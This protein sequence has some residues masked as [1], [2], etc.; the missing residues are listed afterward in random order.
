VPGRSPKNGC[1]IWT[2]RKNSETQKPKGWGKIVTTRKSAECRREAAAS[3]AASKT[4]QNKI[5]GKE[6]KNPIKIKLQ[7][8]SVDRGSKVA[9]IVPLLIVGAFLILMAPSACAALSGYQFSLI[10]S[11][12]SPAPGGGTFV[13]D[14]EPGGLNSHGDMAFGADVS[15]GGEGIFLSQ[16]GQILESGRTDGAAPGGGSFE[17]GFLGPVGLND[18]GDMVFTF[19]LKDFTLPFG[20]NAGLYRYSRASQSL[21]PVV[22]PFVTP[23]PGGGTFQGSFFQPT[24]NSRGDVVFCGIIATD[25]GV[26]NVPDTGEPYVGLGLGVFRS[27]SQGRITSLISP[28]GAAPGGGRFD[29]G[30]E[31]WVNDGGDV[32]FI[33]HIAEK[34]PWS[35]AFRRKPSSSAPWAACMS[36]R[37]LP[38]KSAPSCTRVILPRAEAT[39][40]RSFM[41]C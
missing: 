8:R 17:F 12:G 25:Q 26:H 11:L 32:S 16:N 20:V 34:N 27:D 38:A 36:G 37:A 41:T 24:I 29:Y 31:P 2:V 5:K 35:R 13:N 33:G 10:N 23:A 40:A 28:G 15:T 4:A 9:V 21:A 19:L 30:V 6:R 7:S 18:Q 39:S 22:V 1:R 3:G 14:F